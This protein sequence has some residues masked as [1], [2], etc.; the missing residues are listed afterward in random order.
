MLVSLAA[1]IVAAFC[2]GLGAVMQAIAVRASTRRPALEAAGV[3]SGV[4]PGLVLRML[5]QW[6]FIVSIAIDLTGFVCQ[7]IALRRLPL[8]EVQVIIAG[9]LAVTA[10]CASWL[11]HAVLSLREWL[12]VTAVVVG[13]G[14]LGSS[15]GSEGAATVGIDFHLALMAALAVI[16]AAGVLAG[17]LPS[18]IRTPVLGALAGLGYGVVAVC[19]RILPGYSPHQLVT[20]PAAYTL[21][22][23]G[24]ISF[25]LYASALESGSVTVA[26]AAVILVE[27]VPPAVVGVLLL[28]DTTRPGMAG[29]AVAGFLLALL[30]AVALARF[31]E[32]GEHP[33]DRTV[34]GPQAAAGPGATQAL[35]RQPVLVVEAAPRPGTGGWPGPVGWPAVATRLAPAVRVPPQPGRPLEAEPSPRPDLQPDLQPGRGLPSGRNSG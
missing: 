10:V 13:V 28:G 11:M 19:A 9:N 26:T 32:G 30:S 2:Y 4:D 25:M 12:A 21:A 31:G 8:F 16:A 20:S 27:T 24:I 34:A 6:P 7:V 17:R 29:V 18:R 5:H 3:S 15:A 14:L 1:A 22:A 23:A 35:A 33:T